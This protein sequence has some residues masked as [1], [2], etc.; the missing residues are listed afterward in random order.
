[1]K[2][3]LANQF[4]ALSDPNRLIILEA[5]A[6]GETCGCTI[7]NNHSVTHPTLSYHLK[8]MTDGKLLSA[9]KEGTW[10]KHII[11]RE[12]I[13]EMIDYLSALIKE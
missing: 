12:T 7:I 8:I 1:M 5:L 11:H 9:Y 6:K 10:K 4:R 13:I 3:T 2:K